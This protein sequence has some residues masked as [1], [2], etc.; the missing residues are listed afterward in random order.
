MRLDNLSGID[1]FEDLWFKKLR[2]RWKPENQE[3]NL[4]NQVWTGKQLHVQHREDRTN[5]Y[6]ASFFSPERGKL[7]YIHLCY[8]HKSRMYTLSFEEVWGDVGQNGKQCLPSRTNLPLEQSKDSQHA[9]IGFLGW[10]ELLI[11]CGPPEPKC[12]PHGRPVKQ[13]NSK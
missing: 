9:Y 11:E 7:D 2:F 6:I 10:L 5:P 4:R 8:W 1:L 3:K 13:T 12:V